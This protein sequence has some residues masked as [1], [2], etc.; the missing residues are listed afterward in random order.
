SGYLKYR[1]REQMSRYGIRLAEDRDEADVIVEV[2]VAAF[3]TDSEKFSMGLGKNSRLPEVNLSR[4]DAQYGVV[5]LSMFA[6]LRESGVPI[7]Q[8][9]PLR[10]NASHQQRKFLGIG[11]LRNGTNEL[12]ADKTRPF[13][14]IRKRLP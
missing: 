9:G 13:S 8:S 1:I 7:W 11:P 10:A 5:Q 4:H 12:P 2:G 14:K 6:Y 3:G